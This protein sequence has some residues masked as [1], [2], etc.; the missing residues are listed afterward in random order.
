MKRTR[1][2]TD[3][4]VVKLRRR[5]TGEVVQ[6]C[7]VYIGRRLA[8]GGW[9]LPAS[10]WANPF[11]VKD[12]GSAGQAVRRYDEYVRV[13]AGKYLLADLE[14]LRGK[15]LGCWCKKKPEDP[16]HGDV[17]VQLLREKAGDPD[18]FTRAL[19]FVEAAHGPD[20]AWIRSRTSLVQTFDEFYEEYCYVV[21]A[22]GF[23][24]RTAARLLP[25]ILD[26]HGNLDLMLQ[27]FRN[28]QKCQAMS[29]TYA[30]R[31]SWDTLRA[32]FTDVDSLETL[33]YV[34]P[35][36]KYHLARNIGLAA[37]YAKPDVHLVRYAVARGQGV[38]ALV[39]EVATKHGEPVGVTD[40]ILWIWL[41]HGYGI[42]V[43]ECCA[44]TS[45]RLR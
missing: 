27:G 25:E 29:D 7:D 39:Q 9:R 44:K 3:T 13:G 41:S 33:A 40:F 32:S 26:A 8:M 4:R 35:V 15:V 2:S 45:V 43:D 31:G 22:S 5:A 23:R 20:L 21:L 28:R 14:E 12:S 1:E 17:L 6:G 11:S 34:G 42:L 10:K 19:A 18:D 30:M 36:T 24:A 38:Q 16:C 37:G